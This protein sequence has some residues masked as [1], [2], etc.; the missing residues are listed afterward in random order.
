VLQEVGT[1]KLE[2]ALGKD[3]Q[4]K[5]TNQ[6]NSLFCQSIILTMVASRCGR[7]RR[8]LLLLRVLLLQLLLLL[9]LLLFRC[10][11]T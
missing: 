9:L 8:L 3:G 7:R 4:L 10:I 5:H 11:C 2:R 1:Y 6:L